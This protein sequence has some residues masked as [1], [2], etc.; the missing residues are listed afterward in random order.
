MGITA[1]S[2]INIASGSIQPGH[3][4]SS[5]TNLI[6]NSIVSNFNT[7]L[8][9]SGSVSGYQIYFGTISGYHIASNAGINAI[10]ISNGTVDNTEFNYLDGVSGLIQTQLN[11][12]E[13][14]S[15]KNI[16]NGYCG[17]DSGVKVPTG[18]LPIGT[19]TT[20]IIGGNDDRI[21]NPYQDRKFAQ[22]LVT[23]ASTTAVAVGCTTTFLGTVAAANDSDSA[24][25][26]ATTTASS[27]G[28]VVHNATSILRMSWYPDHTM[29]VKT[30]TGIGFTASR[31]IFGLAKGVQ[32]ALETPTGA[33][34]LFR[35]SNISDRFTGNLSIIVGNGFSSYSGL[36]NYPCSTGTTYKLR[37]KCSP[38]D[39]QFFIN[40]SLV[41]TATG[42]LP[43]GLPA[44]P[45]LLGSQAGII[46]LEAVAK[47]FLWTRNTFTYV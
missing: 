5:T 35:Y 42:H 21:L 8:I 13:V 14:A 47:N 41:Y 11:L 24:W 44:A 23:P 28:A 2:P 31:M 27:G 30:A 46:T 12:R 17:L 29:V 3:L 39:A 43:T 26:R 34:L 10:S 19:G 36:T 45:I 16:A 22:L 4:S 33:C 40:D 18:N 15:N 20:N 1:I 9:P 32:N 38:N 37:I 25:V 6:N 7:I